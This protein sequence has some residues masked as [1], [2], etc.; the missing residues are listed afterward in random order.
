MPMLVMAWFYLA[1]MICLAS[2]SWAAGLIWFIL[3]VAL[4][5]LILLVWLL[6]RRRQRRALVEPPPSVKG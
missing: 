1:L 6:H 5:L 4:P 3:L 2:G